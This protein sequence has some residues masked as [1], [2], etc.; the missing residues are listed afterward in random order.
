MRGDA[1]SPCAQAYLKQTAQGLKRFLAQLPKEFSIEGT[2]TR[3]WVVYT[4][5]LCLNTDI[6]LSRP[7]S[8]CRT[9]RM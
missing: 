2:N 6:D 8:A 3:E 7:W 5:L 4:P 1:L 9:R